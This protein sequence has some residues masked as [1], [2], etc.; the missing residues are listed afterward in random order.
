MVAR[1]WGSQR[2]VTVMGRVPFGD[3]ENVLGLD[4][5]NRCTTL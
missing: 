3:D 1:D 4:S 5:G 2:E